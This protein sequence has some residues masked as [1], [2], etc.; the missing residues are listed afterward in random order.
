MLVYNGW[1]IMDGYIRGNRCF[2]SR[3]S[4][5]KFIDFRSLFLKGLFIRGLGLVILNSVYI[6]CGDLGI[7]ID[8]WGVGSN[9]DSS[10]ILELVECLWKDNLTLPSLC[11]VI[12]LSWIFGCG[13]CKGSGWMT[14]SRIQSFGRVT[15]FHWMDLGTTIFDLKRSIWRSNVSPFWY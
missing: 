4:P 9:Q 12:C 10:E 7:V 11:W 8:L 1:F 3:I 2:R 5:C 15:Y 14:P 6:A 13:G